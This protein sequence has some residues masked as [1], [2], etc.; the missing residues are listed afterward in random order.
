ML[1][2]IRVALT[3]RFS[4]NFRHIYPRGMHAGARMVIACVSTLHVTPT[5]PFWLM[6][7][8]AGAVCDVHRCGIMHKLYTAVIR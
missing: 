8:A 7:L 5:V 6:R 1:R 4:K 3:G 2:G